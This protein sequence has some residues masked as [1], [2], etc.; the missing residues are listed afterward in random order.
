[1]Y[2][3]LDA[4]VDA[5]REENKD[6]LYL[7]CLDEMNLAHVEYYFAEFLSKL[8]INKDNPSIELY[9]NEIYKEISE[10]IRDEIE[11]ISGKTLNGTLEEIETL[12]KDNAKFYGSKC[13]EIRKR[14]KLL[15]KY[16]AVFSIPDNV[17][18]IGTINVD[19]T[20]KSISPK[21][22]D[23]SFII[24]LLKVEQKLTDFD[25]EEIKEKVISVDNFNIINERDLASFVDDEIIINLNKMNSNL[26]ILECG[27]NNRTDKHLKKYLLSIDKWNLQ[28][29]NINEIESDLIAMKLLPRINISFNQNEKDKKNIWNKIINDNNRYTDDIKY[30]LEK[31]N[32]QLD[33]DKILSFWGT[34]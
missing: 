8:E 33:E 1:M 14:I 7:I 5:K 13:V 24:E 23:R 2:P 15:Q 32:K 21:V 4:I 3:F 10:D 28:N 20:T 31:M 11:I 18:F 12:C 19:Q 9:S 16:P 27:Y 29:F 34:Y 25:K 22:I 17:R 26:K 30:K 6:K